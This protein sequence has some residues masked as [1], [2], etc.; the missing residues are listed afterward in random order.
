MMM[1]MKDNLANTIFV[2]AGL[3]LLS[4]MA[5]LPTPASAARSIG[6]G[7]AT[8]L[9]PSTDLT[10]MTSI[11]TNSAMNRPYYWAWKRFIDVN[12][13]HPV[14]GGA[15]WE[16]WASDSET[17]PTC[18]DA[19]A[20]P[21]WPAQANRQKVLSGRAQ[22]IDT[23]GDSS[24]SWYTLEDGT[25]TATSIEFPEEVRRNRSAFDYIASNGF[26]YTEGLAAAFEEAQT[27]IDA[28]GGS[29]SQSLAAAQRVVT[30]PVEAIEIKADWVPMND[31][32]KEDRSS[33]YSAYAVTVDEDGNESS[34][35][36]Y[37]LAAMH[38]STKDIPAWFWATWVNE[39]V[40][41]RCDYIGCEDRFGT[42][43]VYQP[44][45]ETPNY[46]Y[47]APALHPEL[48]AMM[49]SAGLDAA[50]ENYRLVGVQTGF[51][52]TTGQPIL[53][54]NTITEQGNLQ[55]GSCMSC[56]SRA[57][58]DSTGAPLGVTSDAA[59]DAT[60]LTGD[61]GVTDNGTP[62]TTWFWTS[63]N[64]VDEDGDTASYF[65]S[66]TEVV[67]V[68]AIQF[69]FVWGILFANSVDACD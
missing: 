28:A 35:E 38:I 64:G 63:E 18:P 46:P 13:P 6:R 14:T 60:P 61:T 42:T 12:R 41:G 53:M 33:Y 68:T 9:V 24:L 19:D 48:L 67:G 44:P 57:A 37:A 56:H 1:M 25:P 17:F 26:Y 49:R 43:P 66:S 65:S 58:F 47:P 16:T 34:R 22:R 23:E 15:A 2:L 11:A 36:E 5:L 51:V 52:D 20:P 45:N 32:P 55:T 27:A 62:D 40:L 50:L 30:F 21:A 39:K 69:D 54:S 59:S 29:P 3:T 7:P 31:V 10:P 8:S 4:A